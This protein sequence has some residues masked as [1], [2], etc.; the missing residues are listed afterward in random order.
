ME[1]VSGAEVNGA[2][3]HCL[4]LSRAL[5]QRGHHVALVCRPAAWIA[6]QAF[7]AS[8]EIIES[9]LHRWPPDELR[10]MARVARDGAVDVLHTHM[11][12]AH[13][14][15][16][17]LRGLSGVPCVAS[18]HNQ[19]L[20]LHWMFNDRVIAVSDAT[21]RFHRRWNGVRRHRLDV[22]H[23]FIDADHYAS[24]PPALGAGIRATLGID[25][26]CPVIGIIGH[27]IPRKGLGDLLRAL[28][29]ILAAAPNTRVLVVGS[30][31]DQYAHEMRR[32]AAALGVAAHVVWAGYR[33][34]IDAVLA[35]VD[36]VACPSHHE[37]L[38]MVALEA[39]AAGRPV[40]ATMVGGFPECI[41]DGV[42]GLLVPAGK[43]ERLADALISLLR[44]ADR[45][46]RLSQAALA[47]LRE[48]YSPVSQVPRIEAALA[49]AMKARRPSRRRARLRARAWRA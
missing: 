1:I 26:A 30:A 6:A 35:S 40:V 38:N 3:V 12:R 44:D 5:A 34:D 17:L 49:Q 37:D 27:V 23:N 16:V 18:A 41:V 11:S 32:L 2:V 15:G 19:H 46:R 10:R 8:V 28:P 14:F 13:F 24:T 45:R 7:P 9:D 22:I 31:A 48:R 21:A 39:M 33:H 25:S 43:P 29:A 47:R 4:L 20:Q 42:T 36:V